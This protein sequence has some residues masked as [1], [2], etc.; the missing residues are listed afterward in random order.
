MALG[1]E[2]MRKARAGQWEELPGAQ[3]VL[4]F[5]RGLWLGLRGRGGARVK[6]GKLLPLHGPG[7]Q[8]M[9]GERPNL[10][11]FQWVRTY[12]QSLSGRITGEHGA[13]WEKCFS[14]VLHGDR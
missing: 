9:K 10:L 3:R 13:K 1:L 2:N 14:F 4:G 12:T 7:S 11:S 5:S 6:R 8:A